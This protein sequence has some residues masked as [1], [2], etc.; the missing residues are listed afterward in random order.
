MTALDL[1]FETVVV[2]YHPVTLENEK[3]KF[4]INNLL[5]ALNLLKCQVIFTFPN[6]DFGF[7]QIISYITKF[8]NKNKKKYKII[9]NA[10]ADTYYA[11]LKECKIMIGNSSSGLVEAS[12][13][14]IPAI[15]IGTRQDGKIKPKNVIDSDYDYKSIILAY[16]KAN[17]KK[18]RESIKKMIS[19]YYK[20]NSAK[21]FAKK[22]LDLKIDDRLLRKKFINFK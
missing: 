18:F 16:K 14:K 15:N 3:L 10:T 21:I 20:K 19:P 11:L 5:I 7:S 22:I 2:T 12:Y 1:N 4:Q 17:T 9:K 8:A 13:L 6:N